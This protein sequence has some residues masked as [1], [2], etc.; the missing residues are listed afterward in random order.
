[1]AVGAPPQRLGVPKV[2]LI[3]R[4]TFPC[5]AVTS[6]ATTKQAALGIAYA[7]GALEL[8]DLAGAGSREVQ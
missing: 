6:A 3:P 7:S 2:L 1:M 5:F 4:L 8:R